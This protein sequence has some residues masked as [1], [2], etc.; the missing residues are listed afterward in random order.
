MT[1]VVMALVNPQGQVVN[2]IVVDTSKPFRLPPGWSMH[3]W[4]DSVDGPAYEAYLQSLR[5]GTNG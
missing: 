5:G 3:K 2:K 1:L 4:D